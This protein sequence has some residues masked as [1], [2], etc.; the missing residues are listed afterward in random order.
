MGGLKL[1]LNFLSNEG[2]VS[3]PVHPLLRVSRL[4]V[5]SD[6]SA[7]GTSYNSQFDQDLQTGEWT[8]SNCWSVPE[9]K[10]EEDVKPKATTVAKPKAASKKGGKMGKGRSGPTKPKLAFSSYNFFFRETRQSLIGQG[11][12]SGK[13]KKKAKENS[14]MTGFAAMGK[15]VGEQWRGMKGKSADDPVKKR[16]EGLANDDKVRFK[17]VEGGRRGVV[18]R[19]LHA[20]F[21]QT[22]PSVLSTLPRLEHLLDLLEN[23]ITRLATESLSPPIKEVND[24]LRDLRIRRQPLEDTL[25][26]VVVPLNQVLAALVALTLDLGRVVRVRV[27]RLRWLC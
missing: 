4:S 1:F 14:S 22:R 25:R 20:I 12:A 21:T 23:N 19:V 11:K 15:F 24:R 16:L 10:E 26:L 17:S 7:L 6:L 13:M 9:V 3:S 5:A 27:D 2:K 8:G 18:M